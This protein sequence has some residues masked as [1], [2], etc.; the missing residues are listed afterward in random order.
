MKTSHRNP[1]ARVLLA[2]IFLVVSASGL[3][4]QLS[5]P[6]AQQQQA[7]PRIGTITIKFVGM[8]NVSEQIVRANMSLREESELDESLIDRDIRS[9]Y[10]TGLFEFIE[11]KRESRPGNVVNLVVDVTPK[12]RVLAVQFDGNKKYKERRLLKEIKTASNGALDERQIK[13]DAQKIYEFYQKSGYNQAQITYSIDRNRETGFGTV[14]F[15]IREGARVKISAVNFVGN[16]H[17]KAKKLRKEMETRKWH[18]FSWLTGSGRLKDDEFDEDLGKLRDYYKEEGY[19]DVEIPEDK[20]TFDYPKPDKLVITLRVTEGRQYRIGDI[21]FSGNKIYSSRLLRYVPRQKKG[22]IF[23]P[24]KLDKDIE[25]MEDF[26]GRDGYLETRVRL[27]RKPN[28]Q[29]GN[30]DIEYQ[31]TESEKFQVES[32]NIEG[33]TKTKSIVIIR[34]LALGPGDVF[35]SVLMKVS[36]LR[37]E[38]TRFFEDPVNVTPESTNIPGRRNLKIAVTEARTGNLTFGAGFSSLERAVVFAE[39]TQSNFDLFNRRSFFQ[40][41]GQKFRLRFQ[42]GSQSSEVIL[43]FEEPWFLER[44]LSL[45][46]QLLRTSS[47]YNSSFYEEIRTGGEVYLRKR[48]FYWLESRLSYSYEIISID[49]VSTSAPSQIQFLAGE[50]TT[51]K[52]NL[53]LTQDTR[54]KIINTTRGNY[55][56]LDLGLAGGPFGGDNNYYKIEFRG[57]K[58]FP[59]AEFQEQVI[60]V[61]GRVGVA[62]SFGDSD[63]PQT[64]TITNPLTGLPE[65]SLPFTL[66]VPFYDRYYLGGPQTLRGFEF[67]TVGPKD[68]N[69]EP[70][71]GNT[72]GF[73]SIEYSLDVVKPVR[74]ALFYDGGFVNTDP[75]D[76]SPADYN[77]NIGIG[78]RLFVAG[79][80]LSLDFGI[81]LTGDK[82]NKQ[83]TQFNFSFGTRF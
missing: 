8:A 37:L 56:T 6:S 59:I 45:G 61:I 68:S 38:N 62:D 64:R 54:D 27:V 34:E 48:L 76:F 16:D 3:R 69:G 71:G 18:M 10:R 67:R 11:V 63:K 15:K 52:I 41:D 19:L 73:V 46:F 22:Q 25:T 60:S 75:Y 78:L 12:F 7:A 81:P 39:V 33:N 70:L 79:A 53:S 50:S 83:G 43:A 36:K 4:A 17:I 77:D 29:T 65:T 51:S 31:I 74:A 1:F 14:T 9:L 44:E 2:F 26:Y 72:Y 24:S 66:G 30:I 32:I 28:L 57:S 42:I 40:G 58:F 35:S 13:D 47:D 20:I 55:A 82:F 21:S 5:A 80:P 23:V 49:N